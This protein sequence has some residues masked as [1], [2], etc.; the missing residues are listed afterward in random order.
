MEADAHA[1]DL[2]DERI[3]DERGQRK[4]EDECLHQRRSP[5]SGRKAPGRGNVSLS[6]R[7]V[8]AER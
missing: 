6:Q 1:A 7:A 5:V 2:P 3:R 8:P 4:S